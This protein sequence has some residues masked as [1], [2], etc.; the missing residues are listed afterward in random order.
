MSLEVS[1]P[2][3]KV[4]L[5]VSESTAG[6]ILKCPSCKKPFRAPVPTAPTLKPLIVTDAESM[7]DRVQHHNGRFPIVRLTMQLLSVVV[8][9][10]LGYVLLTRIEFFR[11]QQPQEKPVKEIIVRSKSQPAPVVRVPPPTAE[12]PLREERP[13]PVVVTERVTIQNPL[14]GLP[15]NISLPESAQTVPTPIFDL[16]AP[17][18]LSLIGPPEI[19][20]SG[21]TVVWR[22]KEDD[23]TETV[24]ELRQDGSKVFIVWN[25]SAPEDGVIALHNSILEV[26]ADGFQAHVALRSPDIQDP[27]EFDLTKTKQLIICKCDKMPPIEDV[28]FELS[29]ITGLPVSRTEGADPTKLR[30][31]EEAILWYDTQDRVATRLTMKKRGNTVVVEVNSG[32]ALPS[33]DEDVLS[34]PRGK[35][36][37]RELDGLLTSADE[38]KRVIGELRS[39]LSRRQSDLS[40]FRSMGTFHSVNGVRVENPVLVA[41]KNNGIA[42]AQRDIARTQSDIERAEYLIEHRS[43]IEQDLASLNRISEFA[44]EL[45]AL[46]SISFR[47][48]IEVGDHECTLVRSDEP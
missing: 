37:R 23:P 36:K 5:R 9:I 46:S 43:A 40:R 20:L 10:V 27:F 13:E 28:V 1:C 4:A 21:D 24:G 6:S 45:D 8:P 47:F 33:G 17:A 42:A 11:K 39:F 26:S 30:I 31:R 16:T 12:E 15:K 48:Y 34:V 14:K 44:R 41:Q 35:K 22:E 2:H 38:A 25:S 18:V 19:S 29:G 32:F 3:C 7:S